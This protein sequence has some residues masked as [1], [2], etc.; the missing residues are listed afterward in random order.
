[1][2]WLY[3]FLL[4]FSVLEAEFKLELLLVLAFIFNFPL[5]FSVPGDSN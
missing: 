5:C 2:L 3:C 1:M 4:A